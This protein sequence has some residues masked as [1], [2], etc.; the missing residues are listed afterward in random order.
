[1]KKSLRI[2]F[3]IPTLNAEFFLQ[4]CLQSIRKQTYP[5]RLIEIVI[6]DGGSTD[7]TIRIAKSFDARIIKNTK[8][9]QEPGK[10]LGTAHA[11]GEIIFYVDADNI[12]VETKWLENILEPFITEKNITGLIPQTVPDMQSHPIDRYFGYLFTDPFTW[13]VYGKSANPRNYNSIYKPIKKTNNYCVYQFHSNQLPLF[14]FAQG[15]GVIKSLGHG[16]GGYSDD[17]LSGVYAMLHGKYFAYVPGSTLYHHHILTMK[18]YINKYTWRVKNNLQQ[19]YKNVGIKLRT[20]YFSRIRKLRMYLFL[21]YALLIIPAT[22]DSIFLSI[23]HKTTIML[24]HPLMSFMMAVIIIKET[25]LF[26]LGINR[27]I[28]TYE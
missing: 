8:V 19:R 24:I 11:T 23:K 21:P 4:D 15:V 16:A 27:Q 28:G 6:V 9:F 1:M 26:L 5:Q 2:S 13:F 7:N 12:L 25:L 3:V 14:G 17:M 10:T 18:E 20:P 22:I